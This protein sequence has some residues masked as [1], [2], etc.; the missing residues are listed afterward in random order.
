MAIA[1][2]RRVHTQRRPHGRPQPE[3]HRVSGR[4]H[5]PL[6]T[7]RQLGHPSH[8]TDSTPLLPSAR[9]HLHLGNGGSTPATR[10][11]TPLHSLHFPSLRGRSKC[12]M[13]DFRA[14][15]I[16]AS[17]VILIETS[18]SALFPPAATMSPT[19]GT[20]VKKLLL[21]SSLPSLDSIR[22]ERRGG[23][24]G[25][26]IWVGRDTAGFERTDLPAAEKSE[27]TKELRCSHDGQ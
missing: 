15:R 5:G 11:G 23:Q 27:T 18:K 6:E 26:V 19:S 3:D 25:V 24:S 16:S 4:N 10:D 2:L 14:R 20:Q 9:A 8:R 13:K 17:L 7:T 1:A 12:S 21:I 22:D